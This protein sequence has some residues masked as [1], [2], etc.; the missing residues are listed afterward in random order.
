M[1]MIEINGSSILK[2]LRTFWI[3]FTV[4]NVD[5]DISKQDPTFFGG[6]GHFERAWQTLEDQ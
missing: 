2:G 3:L 5:R 4:G 1:E 6:G